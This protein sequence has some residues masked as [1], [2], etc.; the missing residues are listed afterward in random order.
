M[1]RA[2]AALM[3]RLNLLYASVLLMQ[4]GNTAGVTGLPLVAKYR[5]DCSFWT[6][7]FIG[8]AGPL[9]YSASCLLLT[10]TLGRVSPF[11]MM[12]AGMAAF[13]AVFT[14]ALFVSSPQHLI[15]F[16]ALQA[17]SASLFWPMMEVILAE[18]ASG[19]S[20]S[21]RMGLFNIN[22]S[23]ADALGA[24]IAGVLYR[25]WPFAP[26]AF[27]PACMV[28]TGVTVTLAR[29]ASSRSD[30][31]GLPGDE[32]APLDM[33]ARYRKASWV[34]N[35]F[36]F[37]VT[38]VI[39]SVFAAAAK[40]IFKM[41]GPVYGLVI[42]TFNALRT[43]TFFA[44]GRHSAW[45]YRPRLFLAVNSLLGV[46]MA[47]TF[48]AAFL[49]A[50]LAIPAVFISFA[51]AGIG[52]GMTY[53]SS[54]FYSVSAHSTE[55]S[56]AHLHEAVLGAGAALFTAAAGIVTAATGSALSPLALC[57]FAVA[58]GT[59]FSAAYLRPS[60]AGGAVAAAPAETNS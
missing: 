23:V 57:V 25:V 1:E 28:L 17:V 31:N 5:F 30:S 58:G 21:R 48:I 26:F 18:G 43:L 42:A 39:R 27:V 9:T 7:S 34:A 38:G 51:A 8:I 53:T 15:V 10:R 14:A 16:S 49:P 6:L 47:G 2:R 50:A 3:K 36:G 52:V 46:G 44:L 12:Y 13:G 59:A 32:H 60:R 11:K 37:G 19:K 54:I 22:W 41:S 55:D 24:A 4:L 33:I 56:K 45:Q 29:R 35:F 40:D 20:L